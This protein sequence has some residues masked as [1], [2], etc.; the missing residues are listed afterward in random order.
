MLFFLSVKRGVVALLLLSVN[1]PGMAQEK[2]SF[3]WFSGSSSI[4]GLE[5]SAGIDRVLRDSVKGGD[6]ASKGRLVWISE[7]GID[8]LIR[9]FQRI[10]KK[11][12]I[13]EGYRVQIFSGSREK[14]EKVKSRFL[15]EYS[16]IPV[17]NEW[18]PP[19]FQIR[20]GNFRT[21]L[22][23]ERYRQKIL[24]D[25]PN[26]YIVNATIDLPQYGNPGTEKG[27]PEK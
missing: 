17:H 22:Q 9:K 12:P 11:R 23:A 13:L 16:G 15:E 18:N 10:N 27:D 25:F 19:T 6:R 8:S 1:L 26:A 4:G 21:R 2:E 24:G 7:T 5:D 14:A 20:V 3:W